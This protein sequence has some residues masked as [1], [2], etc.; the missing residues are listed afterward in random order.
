MKW[1]L[2][3]Q[4]LQ[5]A[6]VNQLKASN[7]LPIVW[8][9]DMNA[10]R[11]VFCRVTKQAAMVSASGGYRSAATCQAPKGMVVD[12]IF[13]SQVQFSNYVQDRS[14]KVARTTD[15]HLLV[16]DAVVQPAAPVI[17]PPPPPTVTPT[18][19]PTTTLTPTP[20]PTQTTPGG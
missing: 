19:T 12:W 15:H 20:T 6:L 17:P 2:I 8:T 3:G 4:R 7:R 10:K 18:V 5:I 1:R 9:G 11:Q 14:R 16:A 13:G